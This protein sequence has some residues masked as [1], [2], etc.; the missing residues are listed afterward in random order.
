MTKKLAYHVWHNTVM[1][2]IESILTFACYG[3]FVWLTDCLNFTD[4]ITPG[5]FKITLNYLY[6]KMTKI[7][8]LFYHKMTS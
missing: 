7:M 4:M 8:T 6:H 1:I 5:R 3:H 2:Q